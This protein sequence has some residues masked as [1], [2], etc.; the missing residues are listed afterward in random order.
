MAIRRP[1]GK[2]A[3]HHLAIKVNSINHTLTTIS[4]NMEHLHPTTCNKAFRISRIVVAINPSVAIISHLIRIGDSPVQQHNQ[5]MGP[6]NH[7]EAEGAI[8]ATYNGQHRERDGEDTI[9][10]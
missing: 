4:P 1:I 8:L 6:H 7:N 10:A 3:T 5:A 2:T 9:K